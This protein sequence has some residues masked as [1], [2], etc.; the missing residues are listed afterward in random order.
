MCIKDLYQRTNKEIFYQMYSKNF[1]ILIL[2]S[3][4]LAGL[5]AF[6][7]RENIYNKFNVFNKTLEV[8]ESNGENIEEALRSGVNVTKNN[9]VEEVDNVLKYD[10]LNLVNSIKA[11]NPKSTVNQTLSYMTFSFFP[12]IFGVFGVIVATYDR[13]Y[14][15]RKLNAIY[16]NKKIRFISKILSLILIS[17]VVLII[18]LGIT[19][20]INFFIYNNISGNP[21]FE[22]YILNNIASMGLIFKIKQVLFSL[23]VIFIFSIIGF[24]LGSILMNSTSAILVILLYNLLFPITG[25][26]D[27]KNILLYEGSTMFEFI[28]NFTP[29]NIIKLNSS[30]PYIFIFIIIVLLCV[31]T[32]NI[33]KARTYYD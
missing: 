24:I 27:L 7:L 31:I 33:E 26:Y 8:A 22:P 20:I 9:N 21:R 23:S 2:I 19:Y 13:K 30:I 14:K 25:K 15:M 28:G 6:S 16:D 32:Y 1:F 12:I 4:L 18:T 11:V 17:S 10:Y 3:I 29:A 5:N